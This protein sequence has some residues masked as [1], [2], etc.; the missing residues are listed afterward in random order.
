MLQLL[1]T[2]GA[3]LVDSLQHE[4]LQVCK[5]QSSITYQLN[6]NGKKY[7]MLLSNCYCY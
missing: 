7:I 5:A 3:T 1:D 6:L 4:L 2:Q